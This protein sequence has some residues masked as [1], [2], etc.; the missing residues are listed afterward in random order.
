LP[1]AEPHIAQNVILKNGCNFEYSYRPNLYETFIALD[2]YIEG[3]IKSYSNERLKTV[4]QNEMFQLNFPSD[5]LN[6]NT[7]YWSDGDHFSAS[8][9][10]Y[11]GRRV[12][13]KLFK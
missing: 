9:E 10:E 1:R 12:T 3:V 4:S 7:I 2:N 11:F 6:C 13:Q 5:F 8:G